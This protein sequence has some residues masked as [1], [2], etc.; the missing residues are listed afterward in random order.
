MAED[1][2]S[3]TEKPTARRK[4][5]ARHEG[6]VARTPELVTWLV[7]LVGDLSRPVHVP[8]DLRPLRRSCST[9]SA[10]AMSHPSLATDFSVARSGAT[11]ALVLRWPRPWWRS[12]VVALVVNLAQTRGVLT[13]KPLKPSFARINPKTGLKRISQHPLALGGLQADR[14]GSLLS[15]IGLAERL[16]GLLPV[17]TAHGPLSSTA[18]A[19]LVA[20][21]ALS[22]AREVAEIGLV[23][24]VLD[25]VVPVPQSGRRPLKMTREEVKEESKQS[26]GQPLYQGA[27]CAAA[28][29]CCPATA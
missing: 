4:K 7:V 15:L 1:R 28:S 12:M 2:K 19:S 11:G 22:L 13:F 25:Y 29:A 16:V 14:T 27:S 23:L 6:Q 5:E 10:D 17:V 20:A 8:L 3:K 26:E 9:R 18:V 21:R 24:A